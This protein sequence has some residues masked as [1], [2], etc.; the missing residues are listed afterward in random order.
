MYGC[1]VTQISLALILFYIIKQFHQINLKWFVFVTHSFQLLLVIRVA[2]PLAASASGER[3]PA[4][5][6]NMS[7][8]L[9][10]PSSSYRFWRR[11]QLQLLLHASS[12]FKR[13]SILFIFLDLFLCYFLFF[14]A[15]SHLFFFAL[16]RWLLADWLPLQKAAVVAATKSHATCR[17]PTSC[18]PSSQHPAFAACLLCYISHLMPWQWRWLAGSG[19]DWKVCFSIHCTLSLQS[20]VPLPITAT[21]LAPSNPSC[22]QHSWHWLP[23]VAG[24]ILSLVSC[25]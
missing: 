16:L 5:V 3:R 2:C 18:K 17:M 24:S 9:P 10:A 12:V 6:A 15:P 8:T 14:S 1:T 7:A 13:C 23:P 11:L 4:S 25:F 22:H 20:K 21:R 19:G